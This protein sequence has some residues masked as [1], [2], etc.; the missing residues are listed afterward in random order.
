MAS[1][2]GEA[3]RT[4]RYWEDQGLLTAERS[5]AGYRLFGEEMVDRASFLREAQ[6]LGLRLSEIRDLLALR[7]GGVRPCGHVRERLRERR[8]EVRARIRDLRALERELSDRLAW[9]EAHPEPECDDGC[10]YLTPHA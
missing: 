4:L 5:D 1:A 3:V 2:T 6:A 9:A 10:V 7:D 8:A